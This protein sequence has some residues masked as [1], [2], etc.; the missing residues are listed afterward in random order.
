MKILESIRGG[1]WAGLGG[2]VLSL[3]MTDAAW[4]QSYR[5]TEYRI[6]RIDSDVLVQAVE[7]DDLFELSVLGE[8]LWLDLSAVRLRSDRFE[9]E[10]RARD[11]ASRIWVDDA[12][13]YQGTVVGNDKSLVC[14]S[15]V[16]GGIR[17]YVRDDV[18]WIF[19]NPLGSDEHL[20]NPQQLESNS[21]R[22][23]TEFEIDPLFHAPCLSQE[24]SLDLDLTDIPD[25]DEQS[26]VDQLGPPPISAATT[27]RAVEI[28]VSADAEFF[29]R[30]GAGSV[31]QVEARLNEVDA[32]YRRDLGLT[33]QLT[34]VEVW[35]AEPDPY[36]STDPATLLGEFRTHWQ[37]TLNSVPRDLAHLFT[38]KD[39]DGTTVG[40]AF[41]NVACVSQFAFG[42]TQDLESADLTTIVVAHELGHNLGASHDPSGE[43]PSYIMAPGLSLATLDQFS[44]AS[45]LEVADKLQVA[46]CLS[47]VTLDDSS[48]SSGGGGGGGG[49][50]P[51]DPLTLL[52]VA[53]AVGLALSA[54]ARSAGA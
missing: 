36:T 54:R 32:I 8:T 52:I 34:H 17:G 40:L 16:E 33:L 48:G 35:Q 3:A 47:E 6:H 15:V 19:I 7:D 45:I 21:H 39:L 44:A 26:S 28:G 29:A 10:A 9:A 13:T 22:V 41:T 2:L 49:G 42:L 5:P 31:A 30:Y 24:L 18:G 11:D 27:V 51:I 23:H 53:A 38:A 43:S 12:R 20:S 4:S 25:S 46:S 50:G 37:T 1:L 14:L